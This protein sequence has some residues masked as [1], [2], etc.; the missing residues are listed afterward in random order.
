MEKRPLK[1]HVALVADGTR[2]G[3]RG[4]AVQLGAA[5]KP[6]PATARPPAA[7]RR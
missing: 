4:V 6:E 3:G 1:G 7:A 2:G 5:G